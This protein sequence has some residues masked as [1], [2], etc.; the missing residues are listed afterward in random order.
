[1]AARGGLTVEAGLTLVVMVFALLA[2][3][4][5]TTDNST[6]FRPE[7]TLLAFAGAWL[8][9]FAIQLWRKGRPSLAGISLI[10]LLAAAWVTQN[11]LG[12]IRDGGWRVFW[13]EYSVIVIA[14]LWFAALAAALLGQVLRRAGSG[15]TQA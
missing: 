9:V 15:P 13:P 8:L 12:H 3:D 11:G 4:D 6:G 14:W 5:I 2:L 1:M 7:Y 10:A